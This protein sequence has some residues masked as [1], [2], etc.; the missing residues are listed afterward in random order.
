MS[1][2]RRQ[3]NQA[4]SSAKWSVLAANALSDLEPIPCWVSAQSTST[5][6]SAVPRRMAGVDIAVHQRVG[7]SAPGQV[8]VPLL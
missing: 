7:E 4:G 1:R 2:S 6:R 3:A 5:S 8:G